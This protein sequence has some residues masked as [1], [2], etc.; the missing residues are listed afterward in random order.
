MCGDEVFYKSAFNVCLEYIASGYNSQMLNS[1]MHRH[2]HYLIRDI[3]FVA[4]FMHDVVL[5]IANV[6]PTNMV[7]SNQFFSLEIRKI[8]VA[9][10]SEWGGADVYYQLAAVQ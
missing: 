2:L 7:L 5:A 9:T 1:I 6:L 10:H 3:E 8:T 4:S